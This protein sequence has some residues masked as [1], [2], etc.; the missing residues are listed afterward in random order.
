MTNNTCAVPANQPIYQALLE[1]A[2]S[3][4]ADKPYQ[5]KAY[6]KAA[7]TVAAFNR[8][9]YKGGEF[10]PWELPYIGPKIESFINDVIDNSPAPVPV[11]P[12]PAPAPIVEPSEKMSLKQ[13]LNE[14]ARYRIQV[15][16]ANPANLAICEMLM[17][18]ADKTK[19]PYKAQAYRRA[20][21]MLAEAKFEIINK[22]TKFEQLVQLGLS[23]NGSITNFV[24]EQ[25]EA[26]KW[27]ADRELDSKIANPIQWIASN[28]ISLL[29]DV[30]GILSETQR[31]TQRQR[32]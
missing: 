18:K 23:E 22:K 21:V 27:R 5:A 31:R 16:I 7:Q 1:K 15:K 3:Y 10:D 29:S 17:A 11:A 8:D 12:A 19:N 20:A 4:S 13:R 6:R 25:V 26:E 28:T 24:Y 32:S 14:Q 2:A 30:F 9:L